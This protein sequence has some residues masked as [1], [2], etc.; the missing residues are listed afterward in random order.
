MF[1]AF[2]FINHNSVFY[3]EPVTADASV[4]YPACPDVAPDCDLT[5]RAC[6]SVLSITHGTVLDI[7]LMAA[8]ASMIYLA[9]S[10]AAPDTALT[11][12]ACINMLNF[13]RAY[14]LPTQNPEL[15]STHMSV[16]HFARFDSTVSCA[17]AE[18]TDIAEH[19]RSLISSLRFPVT[20]V[21]C[22]GF[23]QQWYAIH[24]GCVANAF[25]LDRVLFYIPSLVLFA[26][27]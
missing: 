9:C 25:A 2:G 14:D 17:L 21:L 8:H 22:P 19:L 15:V 11:E 16:I 1:K 7:K 10:D 12:R 23:C 4:I 6:I 27:N 13:S 24:A 20:L 18:R 3:I 26:F 5:E